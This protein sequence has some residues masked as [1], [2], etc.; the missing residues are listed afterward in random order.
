M[1]P[2]TNCTNSRPPLKGEDR[3][4]VQQFVHVCAEFVRKFVQHPG[5][6]PVSSSPASTREP[7]SAC[8]SRIRNSAHDPKRMPHRHLVDLQ[9]REPQCVAR[10]ENFV[11]W[12]LKCLR[13]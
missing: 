13:G 12:R 4:C 8:L 1:K 11:A 7:L 9:K 10:T 6:P 2:C 5:G 3:E